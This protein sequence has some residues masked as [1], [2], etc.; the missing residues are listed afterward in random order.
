M[1][2]AF[3]T[4]VHAVVAVVAHQGVGYPVP[5]RTAREGRRQRVQRG[6]AHR[7][8]SH[9]VRPAVIGPVTGQ[10]L[11][12]HM[13]VGAGN[14]VDTVTQFVNT[15]FKLN[16]R[17]TRFVVMD[18]MLREFAQYRNSKARSCAFIGSIRVRRLIVYR[19]VLAFGSGLVPNWESGISNGLI[20]P[21]PKRLVPV[22][23]NYHIMIDE[24]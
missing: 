23:T 14:Y 22:V 3:V 10:E 2:E 19:T 7:G 6:L 5:S 8:L 9:D 11:M 15:V 4:V 13:T 1:A 21:P 17:Y 24:C 20:R 16:V 12:G 18:T